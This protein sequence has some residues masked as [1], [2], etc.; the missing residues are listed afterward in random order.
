M[1]PLPN[2][3]LQLRRADGSILYLSIHQIDQSSTALWTIQCLTMDLEPSR[4]AE[5]VRIAWADQERPAVLMSVLPF[6]GRD[7]LATFHC[8]PLAA[9]KP[10]EHGL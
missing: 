5:A 3:I 9:V 4:M 2:E 8:H 6:S 7:M 10:G 1:N